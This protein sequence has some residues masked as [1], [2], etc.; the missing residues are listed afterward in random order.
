MFRLS[1]HVVASSLILAGAGVMA[2]QCHNIT[3]PVSLTAQNSVFQVPVPT[4]DIESTNFI[5]NALQSTRN[6]G[7]GTSPA[8]VYT[9]ISGQYELATTYCEPDGGPSRVL[10]VLTHGIGFDRSYWDF[11]INAYNYSY[12][13]YALAHGYST[14]S[15]DRIGLGE[16]TIGDPLNEIQ[17]ALEVAALRELTL[18]ARGGGG[19]IPT[20]YE[21]VVHVGHSQGSSYTNALTSADPTISDGIVLT[22]FGHVADFQPWGIIGLHL[23]DAHSRPGMEQYPHGYLA[24]GDEIAV[25]TVFFSPGG[26]F[27]PAVL[28]AAYTS[29]QPVAIGEMLTTGP[30]GVNNMTGPVAVVTGQADIIFCGVDC[31]ATG[32]LNVSSLL[33]VSKSYY[34]KTSAFQPTVI[35]GAG[36][37]LNLVSY[38]SM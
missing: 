19:G 29:A 15:W 11:P 24:P 1:Y 25:Q 2:R 13:N 21:K 32:D 34:P 33:D 27:D 30:P 31:Y 23:A 28:D 4:N 5:L 8:P 7:T 22:G 36:H 35:D 38:E 10:Q 6:S 26:H 16:S 14:L 9:N 20:S 17:F 18:L 3:V 12:V 37:G